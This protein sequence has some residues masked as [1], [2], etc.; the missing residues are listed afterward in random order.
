MALASSLSLVLRL[1]LRE[2]GSQSLLDF[3]RDL[4]FGGGDWRWWR[5]GWVWRR[6]WSA[7][8]ESVGGR[9]GEG[10][11]WVKVREGWGVYEGFAPISM[12]YGEGRKGLR[13]GDPE[14]G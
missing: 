9:E 10:L 11:G 13:A 12:F 8:Y 5:C 1:L 4:G 7:F 2:L 6:I 3:A 14:Q